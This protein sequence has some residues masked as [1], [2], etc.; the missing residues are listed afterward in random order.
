MQ[1]RPAAPAPK[2]PVARPP[3]APRTPG[4]KVLRVCGWLAVIGLALAALGALVI[5][6]VF[7]M[8]SRNLPAITKVGD[9]HPRQVT[10]ILDVHGD[11]IG[12]LYTDERRTVVKFDEVPPI[13]VDAF[14]A[15][16]DAN[17]WTHAG[18]DYRGMVRAFFTNLRRAAPPKARA[19][20]PSRS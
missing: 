7:W 4:Q 12:E 2:R 16:E 5:A 18:I 1:P 15:A 3:R 19:R 13:L 6:G 17:F 8:Y 10:A 14:V 9:Y 20:S 11:R